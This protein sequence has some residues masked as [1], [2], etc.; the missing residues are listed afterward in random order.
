M[1]SKPVTVNVVIDAGI[2]RKF[3]AFDNLY[4]R[5]RW[6]SPAVF[7]FI[8]SAS[9]CVCFAMRG[10]AAHAVML[11]CVLLLAGLGFPVVYLWT[12]F[13]S[14]KS[15]IKIHKLEKPQP[16]Y[17]LRLSIEPDGVQVTNPGGEFA[18]YEWQSMYGVYR[19]AGCTYL[20]VVSNKAF[21]LPDGQA[22]EGADA[23]WQLLADM[24]PAEKLHDCRRIKK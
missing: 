6:I 21:L 17:S 4:L 2:F 24:L 18:K 12:F 19:V 23:L 16:A 15:Q 3:A 8:M 10:S 9:A 22:D 14:I 5:R 7:A 13:G 1:E 20:Y 11:G